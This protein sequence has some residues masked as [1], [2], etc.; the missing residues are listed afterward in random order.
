MNRRAHRQKAAPCGGFAS[1]SRS[2]CAA[3]HISCASVLRSRSSESSTLSESSIRACRSPPRVEKAQNPAVFCSLRFHTS[4]K[5]GGSSPPKTAPLYSTYSRGASNLS[6]RFC[7]VQLGVGAGLR[8]A[9]RAGVARARGFARGVSAVSAAE[10]AADAPRSTGAGS[11]SDDTTRRPMRKLFGAR[12]G[13]LSPPE[14]LSPLGSTPSPASAEL[15][16]G[17]PPPSD[18]DSSS[19]TMKPPSESDSLAS[20]PRP[21]RERR[22]ATSRGGG[23]EEGDEAGDE[24]E[25]IVGRRRAPASSE[26]LNTMRGVCDRGA[27]AGLAGR[28]PLAGKFSPSLSSL[29]SERTTRRPHPGEIIHAGTSA[30]DGRM[31]A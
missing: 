19:G 22:P 7:C 1:P 18:S 14:L 29:S 16:A 21:A 8:P 20:L 6:P 27:A 2:H 13:E 3:W 4:G 25:G 5:S 31:A 9:A 10:S 24:G 23:G 17:G 11:P 28:R 12:S 30:R 26:P 15:P